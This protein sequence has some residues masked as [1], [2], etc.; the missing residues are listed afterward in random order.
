MNYE[1]HPNAE[2]ELLESVGF[3][4]SK[5]RGLGSAFIDE[6]EAVLN[7]VCESPIQRKVERA[8]NIRRIP[9]HRFPFAIIYR[10]TDSV[11]QILA[12]AHDRRRPQYW[13]HR[14]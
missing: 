9:L 13:L 14:L 3:Y 7:L 2:A 11:I 5:V 6:L 12:V 10:E 4:E 8:P 1:F